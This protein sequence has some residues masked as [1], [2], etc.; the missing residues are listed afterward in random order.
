MDREVKS[1]LLN[2]LNSVA[3]LYPAGVPNSVIV[4]PK[5]ERALSVG[6]VGHPGWLSEVGAKEL[7]E[8]AVVKGMQQELKEGMFFDSFDIALRCNPAFIILL[9]SSLAIPTEAQLGKLT[10]FHNTK[11]MRTHLLSE[12]I[13][14]AKIKRQ[15]WEHLKLVVREIGVS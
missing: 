7:I 15:F 14:D 3:P 5:K 8:A 6:F 10:S 13:A 9:G 11:I 2:Y 1:D 4:S 12:V